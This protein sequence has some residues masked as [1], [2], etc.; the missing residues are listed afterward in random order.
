MS[1]QDLATALKRAERKG[2]RRWVRT[3]ADEQAVMEG[4]RFDEQ[5][6]QFVVDFFNEFLV[7][8][9]GQWAGQPFRS[10]TGS[11]TRW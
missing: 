8:T 10:W 4:C 5:A 9:L 6:G 11:V 2:W 3:S 7:H 1:E